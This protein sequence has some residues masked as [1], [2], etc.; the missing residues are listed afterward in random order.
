MTMKY[1]KWTVVTVMAIALWVP[2]HAAG[3]ERKEEGNLVIEDIPD[4]PQQ[5]VDRMMQYQNTRSAYIH[6]WESGGRGMLISTRFGNTY[7][8][9]FV[10]RP[11]GTR[12]QITFFTEPVSEA[13]LCPDIDRRGF[14]FNKDIGG[15][16]F[17]QIY[18]FDMNNGEYAML[19][20]GSSLHGDLR[21]SNRGDRF[22]YFN[23]QR[24]GRD[25]DIY[26]G[27]PDK[28]GG[29]IPVL[30]EGGTW[31]PVHWSPDDK[32][33]LVSKYVSIN[34]SYYYILDVATGKTTQINPSDE[35]IAYGA[36]LWAKDGKGV[37]ITSDQGSEFLRLKYNDL[38]TKRFTELTADI[39]WDVRQLEIS[40]QG[41]KLAFTTNEDGISKLYILE[42]K[43]QK[44]KQ[45]T[46][47][48][49]GRVYGLNFHPDGTRLALVLNTP[50][51]PGDI[52]VLDL[53]DD[54]LVRW[55]YSEVG[56]LNTDTFVVPEL[57][58]YPTF[59][60]VDGKQRMIPAFYYKPGK[61]DGPFP[62]LV[63]IHGGPEAQYVPY[64][65]STTQY[66]VNELGIAV[67]APNVRGSSG[68]GK[69]YLKLDDGYKREDSVRD[70]G[71]LLDWIEKQP[72]LDASRVAVT[73]GSYGGYM[74]LSSM[75][76]YSDRLRCG[77]DVVGISNF[78]TFLENTKE[79]RR[80]LRRVEYGDERD[81]EMR[82]HL[83]K[84]SPTT[85]AAKITRPMFIAQGLN[86]PRVPV[87]EAEQINA[88][89]RKNG[90]DVWYMLAKDEG[91]GFGKKKNRDYY[92]YAVV[93]FL[94]EYLFK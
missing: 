48:P 34:D 44:Y 93:L 36:A 46:D 29:G 52:Y 1:M 79:Y 13:T 8:L 70:I 69:N 85:N 61:G 15:G 63:D 37:Y 83:I 26:L 45:V 59:D 22:A 92:N 82:K 17:Y 10:E 55:T 47:I 78:V 64:F 91:H 31:F 94:E 12:R 9:H 35:K 80:D 60:K 57:I 76:H 53:R 27:F 89:I 40:E 68:Y 77:I 71:K 24:N 14:L 23:T 16:E 33:L 56:G 88:E 50:Q 51:T 6:D 18:Y 87:G 58:H 49:V 30:E 25:W 38:E 65:R 28:P 42:T 90:G 3:I 86:D 11:G 54:S 2:Y 39:P 62:V 19:T 74:V 66:Y 67:L 21:W 5:I 32:R 4:I 73:G 7:Q 43:S 20:D 81:P 41:D 84:I 72:E 75:I